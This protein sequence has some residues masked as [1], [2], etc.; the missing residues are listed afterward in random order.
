MSISDNIQKYGWQYQYVF[1]ENGDKPS[2]AYSIGFYQSFSHPEVMIFGLKKEIM[3]TLLSSIASDIK[4]NVCFELDKRFSGLLNGG[5]E[6][7]FK[8]L[9]ATE[10]SKFAG[11]ALRYYGHDI[12]VWV[13]F[14]PDRNNRLPFEDGCEVTVQDEAV[15][16]V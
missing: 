4:N 7:M 3:H 6:T 11:T 13:L 2:F 15:N 1:D 12:P 16:V 10:K 14:W 9:R 5:F 8:Q